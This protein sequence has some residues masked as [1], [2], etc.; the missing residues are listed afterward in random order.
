MGTQAEYERLRDQ[1]IA[2]GKV[3]GAVALTVDRDGVTYESAAGR[4]GRSPGP[5]GNGVSRRAPG[6]P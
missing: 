3:A 4:R 5:G 1:A 6:L 2:D